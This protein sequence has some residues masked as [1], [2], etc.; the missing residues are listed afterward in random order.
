M[1]QILFSIFFNILFLQFI[2]GQEIYFPPL[3]NSHWDTISP[4]EL[5]W[6]IAKIPELFDFLQRNNTKAF[7]LLKNGKIVLEKYFGNF[8]QESIWM[9]A[10]A[11]KI[12]TAT[13]VGI[14]QEEG[15]LSINDKTSK[16]LG[17]GWTSCPKEKENLITIRHQLTMTSGL[18]DEVQDPN[19]TKP[20]CLQYKADAGT[21][22]SYHNAPYTLLEK[23][24]EQATSKN[25]NIYFNQ[26]IRSKIGMDG[27]WVKRGYNNVYFSTARSMARF[28]ILLLNKGVWDG[29]RIIPEKHFNEMTNTSQNLN[30]SYGY[31]FWLNGKESFMVP[32]SQLVLPG[33]IFKNAPE[34]LISGLGKDGQI[35]N[36]SFQ[37]SIIV[38]RMGEE[39]AFNPTMTLSDSIWKYLNR[40]FV[41]TASISDH[42]G[43]ICSLLLDSQSNT[44]EIVWTNS[45]EN[46]E[47]RIF[48]IFGECLLSKQITPIERLIIDFNNYPT[49]V[50]FI[51]IGPKFK[52][53]LNLSH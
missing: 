19:C 24:V 49:G 29:N 31:L 6:N 45:F 42:L 46:H 1:K 15:Y 18:D 50:Y 21:R 36:V 11:G 33:P 17:E 5:N 22:W 2:F 27:L 44:I 4:S 35:L 23:V 52:K 16:F 51:K 14:A 28:G 43:E 9:W 47:I 41:P 34:D 7:I 3:D 30:K 32:N 12:L 39:P 37:K 25:Y 8:S 48:N 38:V 13:L 40:I 26:K 20:E 53:I 10:S